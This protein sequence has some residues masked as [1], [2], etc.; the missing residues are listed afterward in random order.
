[1]DSRTLVCADWEHEI[2][3]YANRLK[4]R[5]ILVGTRARTLPHRLIFSNPLE[6]LL[7]TTPCD[8]ALYR[9]P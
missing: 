3:V 9:A 2:A 7:R 1:M 8:I 5:L 6:R 4:T